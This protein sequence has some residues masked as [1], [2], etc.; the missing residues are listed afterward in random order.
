MDA[1]PSCGRVEISRGQESW[2]GQS[3]GLAASCRPIATP[4]CGWTSPAMSA[5]TC[6]ISSSIDWWP[7]P[8]RCRT[9]CY[10]S[11]VWS[12]RVGYVD[13][14][15]QYNTVPMFSY[16]QFSMVSHDSKFI[17]KPNWY[18]R[19]VSWILL[20]NSASVSF[21]FHSHYVLK[22]IIQCILFKYKNNGFT[23]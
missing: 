18:H 9:L 10:V 8:A 21:L 17:V 20:L 11:Y 1:V 22:R 23:N 5:S 14:T 4:Q 12:G 15:I 13:N 19:I 16:V 7:R 3:V 6:A 2:R